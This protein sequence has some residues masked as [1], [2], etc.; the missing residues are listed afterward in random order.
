M[1][2]LIKLMGSIFVSSSNFFINIFAYIKMSKNSSAKCYEN[3][4]ERLQ[5]KTRER[6]QSLSKEKNKKK[7]QYRCEWHKNL[8]E[9][10]K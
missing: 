7:H 3:N 5:R 8:P 9:D 2:I 4:K 1:K 10:E 6:Y